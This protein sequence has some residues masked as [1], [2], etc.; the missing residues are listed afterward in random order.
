MITEL[1]LNATGYRYLQTGDLSKAIETFKKASKYFP[2]S[3]NVYDSL[4]EGYLKKGEIDLAIKNYAK[5][6]QMNPDN[7]NGFEKLMKLWKLKDH[8]L[9]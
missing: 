1:D 9:K 6:I 3:W 7:S 8:S 2:D 5:S 4:G